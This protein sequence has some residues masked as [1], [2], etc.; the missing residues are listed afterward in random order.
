[1]PD[2][3]FT[4]E[5]A[6][7]VPFAAA[8]MLAFKLGIENRCA[9]EKVHTVALR[10]QLQIETARRHYSAGEQE[11]LLDLFGAPNRWG[12]TLHNLLWI[13]AN[14]VVPGFATATVAELQICCTFDFN[15][16][17]TKY[18]AALGGGDLPL[19]FLFS[20]TVF[21]EDTE[22]ALQAAP[23]SWE[24]EARY[25]LPVGVWREMMDSYYPNTVCL[26]LRRDVFERLCQYKT[27]HGL[28]TWEQA[29]E[30]VLPVEEAV[31]R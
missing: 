18:F 22:G 10:C 27:Q 7:V 4:V 5:G 13:N 31:S 16:A 25:K 14:M 20:G 9:G 2:L 1:M 24:Q 12:Q 11:Q 28:P 3:A 15:V 26:N 17:T 19:Q 8:P 23:I 29:L 21:Y 30:S 6:S